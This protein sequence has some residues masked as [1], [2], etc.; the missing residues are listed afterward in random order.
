MDKPFYARICGLDVKERQGLFVV[1]D[2]S[3]ARWP[4]LETPNKGEALAFC[5]APER[6][7]YQVTC[8]ACGSVHYFNSTAYHEE[9]CQSKTCHALAFDCTTR[10]SITRGEVPAGEVVRDWFGSPE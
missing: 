2:P 6:T 8:R 10:K 5:S 3:M 7:V 1:F 4:Y 9:R